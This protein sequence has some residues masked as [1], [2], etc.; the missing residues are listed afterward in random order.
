M[1]DLEYPEYVGQKK[2]DYLA[3][4]E[5]DLNDL[6]TAETERDIADKKSSL[7]ENFF[8][9]AQ[10]TQK[11]LEKAEDEKTAKIEG[12]MADYKADSDAAKRKNIKNGVSRSSIAAKTDELLSNNF[13]TEITAA[14]TAANKSVKSIESELNALNEDYNRAVEK[15][16]VGKSVAIKQKVNELKAEQ[17]K[18]IKE[19]EKYNAAID[20]NKRMYDEAKNKHDK[21]VFENKLALNGKMVGDIFNQ[22]YALD[23][24][25]AEELLSDEDVKTAL[26][27]K[28]E[29]I[30]RTYRT[31]FNHL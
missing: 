14:L 20:E 8:D 19:I 11:K 29:Y 18:K 27:D 25:A 31:S 21:E 5:D 30:C 2:I 4:G 17:A 7:D 9:A 15:L 22:L 23:R 24:T 3:V 6:A 16:D 12:A 1:K 13:E 26:G 10:K 28:Y